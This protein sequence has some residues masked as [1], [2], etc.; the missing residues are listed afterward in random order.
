MLGSAR[1]GIK[2]APTALNGGSHVRLDPYLLGVVMSQ[3]VT[4]R[5]DLRANECGAVSRANSATDHDDARL[6]LY[7]LGV[8]VSLKDLN[9]GFECFFS[10]FALCTQNDLVAVLGAQ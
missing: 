5:G 3:R 1:K 9:Q 4:V 6:N 8:V 10:P 2:I 7:L